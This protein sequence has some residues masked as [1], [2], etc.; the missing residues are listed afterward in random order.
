[1]LYARPNPEGILFRLLLPLLPLAILSAGC[2]PSANSDDDD[3]DDND[4]DTDA[5]TDADSDADSDT[6]TDTDTDSDTDSDTDTD[7]EFGQL[8]V[9]NYSS[10][11]FVYLLQIDGEDTSYYYELLD[12]L[13]LGYGDSLTFDIESG[14]YWY[15]M[16]IDEY[17]YCTYTDA[18][19]VATGYAYEWDVYSLDG[20]WDDTYGCQL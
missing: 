14:V 7:T 3:D 18:Y 4:A 9:T 5:D 17:G 12:G 20:V 15:T 1:M 6:D 8:T 19:V 13:D 16:A 10:Y 11:D 2:I